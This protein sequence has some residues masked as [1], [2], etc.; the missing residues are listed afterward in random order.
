MAT[1]LFL[2]VP[3]HKQQHWRAPREGCVREE[4]S[5]LAPRAVLCECSW[6]KGSPE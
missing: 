5:A 1:K 3:L 6:G 4:A 2:R